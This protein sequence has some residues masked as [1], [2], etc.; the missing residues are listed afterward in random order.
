M[1]INDTDQFLVNRSNVTYTVPTSELMAELLDD[2]LML[3]NRGNQTC[4]VFESTGKE[5]K[6][7]LNPSPALDITVAVAPTDPNVGDTLTAVATASGGTEPYAYTYQ[8]QDDQGSSTWTDISGAELN[9]LCDSQRRCRL[10]IPVQSRR[11]RRQHRHRRSH[12]K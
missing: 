5:V 9:D 10:V 11:H 7:S 6:D 8:W 4:R 1:S 3:V 2:D 12:V